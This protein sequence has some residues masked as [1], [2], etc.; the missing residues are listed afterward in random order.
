MNVTK[1]KK[2]SKIPRGTYKNLAI[3]TADDV[4]VGNEGFI[5]LRGSLAK[6]PN[7]IASENMNSTSNSSAKGPIDLKIKK[8]SK[9]KRYPK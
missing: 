1:K 7:P 9:L 6:N 3:T 2:Q 5:R 8:D 4:R